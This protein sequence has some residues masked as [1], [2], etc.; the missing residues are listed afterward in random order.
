MRSLFSNLNNAVTQGT[1][2]TTSNTNEDQI[3]EKQFLS[4]YD[5]D[6]SNAPVIRPVVSTTADPLSD[7]ESILNDEDE[8]DEFSCPLYSGGYKNIDYDSSDR[9]VSKKYKLSDHY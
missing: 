1:M 8:V 2:K 9:H 7:D 5:N 3:V 6:K 4:N